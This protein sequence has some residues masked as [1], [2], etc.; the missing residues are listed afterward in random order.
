MNFCWNDWKIFWLFKLNLSKLRTPIHR[1]LVVLSY[2]ESWNEECFILIHKHALINNNLIF[3]LK[4]LFVQKIFSLNDTILNIQKINRNAEV[5]KYDFH[6][7][8]INLHNIHYEMSLD[9]FLWLFYSYIEYN[10]FHL[11]E[12]KICHTLTVCDSFLGNS[13]SSSK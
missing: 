7:I 4:R 11:K 5:C 12:K 6:L 8:F 13:F 3:N 9:T 1:L 10:E 2:L